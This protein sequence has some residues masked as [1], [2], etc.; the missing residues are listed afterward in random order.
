VPDLK[1]AQRPSKDLRDALYYL[2]NRETHMFA[3]TETI[4]RPLNPDERLA[5]DNQK[6]FEVYCKAMAEGDKPTA[7]EAAKTL[8][9]KAFA[10]SR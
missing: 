2:G 8:M 5:L 3:V 1:V 4:E 6:V 10:V 7:L 9:L